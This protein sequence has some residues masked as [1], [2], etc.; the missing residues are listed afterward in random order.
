MQPPLEDP[1]MPQ[2][3]FISSESDLLQMWKIEDD[4]DLMLQMNSVR[5][6]I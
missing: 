6:Q 5:V 4:R 3:E 1:Q 2:F